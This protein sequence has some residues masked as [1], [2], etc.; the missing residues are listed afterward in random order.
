MFFKPFL[1][2]KTLLEGK[3]DPFVPKGPKLTHHVW[4]TDCCLE[5]CKR[6]RELLI[7][8]AVKTYGLLHVTPF[9]TSISDFS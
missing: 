4:S 2:K 3:R 9:P 6:R 1:L 7:L 8:S 5:P